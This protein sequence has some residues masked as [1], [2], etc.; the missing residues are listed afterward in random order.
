MESEFMEEEMMLR[1]AGSG[2]IVKA[3]DPEEK[4]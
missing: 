4:E 1:F 2:D 3:P